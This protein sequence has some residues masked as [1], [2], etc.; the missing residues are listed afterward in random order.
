M[1]EVCFF[2]FF[3]FFKLIVLKLMLFRGLCGFYSV[4]IT[5]KYFYRHYDS[6]DEAFKSRNTSKYN[7][8]NVQCSHC[9]YKYIVFLV[10][11]KL[12][13]PKRIYKVLKSLIHFNSSLRDPVEIF[14]VKILQL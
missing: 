5:N 10:Y 2:T 13:Y 8:F 11:I 7:T 1:Y 6:F 3:F 9:I 4:K 14:M 12:F